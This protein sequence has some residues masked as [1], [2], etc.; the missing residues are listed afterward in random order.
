MKTTKINDDG[1]RIPINTP[2]VRLTADTPNNAPGWVAL[3]DVVAGA[4]EPSATL[5]VFTTDG[6]SYSFGLVDLV[7]EPQ[8]TQPYYAAF[9]QMIGTIL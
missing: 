4:S 6:E 9:G 1:A 7:Q 3:E 8:E 2:N 5:T